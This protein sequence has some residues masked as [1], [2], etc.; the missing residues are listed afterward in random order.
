[1]SLI[2]EALKKAQRSRGGSPDSDALAVGEMLVAKRRPPTSARMILLYATGGLAAFVL[3]VVGAVYYLN[4]P[5]PRP[6]TPAPAPRPVA[7]A[8]P[9]DAPAVNAPGTAAGTAT[10]PAAPAA[11]PAAKSTATAAVAV[12]APAPTPVVEEIAVTP[13]P[14]PAPAAPSPADLAARPAAP[15][16]PLPDAIANAPAVAAPTP[17]VAAKADE[18]VQLYLE[19]LR[20]TAVRA[21]GGSDSRVMMNDRVYRVNDI[22]ERNLVLRLT[23]VEANQLTFTDVNGATYVKYF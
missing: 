18:R 14:T 10:T 5:A 16:A 19:T 20:I 15:L 9:A 4:R 13:T 22:V 11:I 1:M 8:D 3:C 2:N 23:K 12:P 17:A 6:P 7:K 21:L